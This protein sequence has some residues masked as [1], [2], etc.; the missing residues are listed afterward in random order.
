[1]LCAFPPCALRPFVTPIPDIA[2]LITHADVKLYFA[3]QSF[4]RTKLQKGV[5]NTTFEFLSTFLR[6]QYL[7]WSGGTITM[8]LSWFCSLY[9][10]RQ[11]VAM[12][13]M[14]GRRFSRYHELGQYAF[15]EPPISLLSA[16]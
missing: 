13:E 3:V 16:Q 1:M 10:L 4:T 2:R 7:T 6:A 14:D 8:V 11:L 5:H 15:G 12:H 9:T